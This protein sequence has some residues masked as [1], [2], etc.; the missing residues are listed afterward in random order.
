MYLTAIQGS[1]FQSWSFDN[2]G[3]RF[4]EILTGMAKVRYSQSWHPG[5]LEVRMQRTVA[6]CIK[7]PTQKPQITTASSNS[8]WK[9]QSEQF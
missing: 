8:E 2:M 3:P 7:E 5:N 6:W 4:P 9:K 1:E